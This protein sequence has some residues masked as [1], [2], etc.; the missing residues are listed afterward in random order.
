[1]Q[2]IVLKYFVKIIYCSE[3]QQENYSII[4]F[5]VLILFPEVTLIRYIPF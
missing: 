4:I 2:Y 1:M 3:N 5:P